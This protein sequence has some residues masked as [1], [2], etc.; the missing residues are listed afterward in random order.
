VAEAAKDLGVIDDR[1]RLTLAHAAEREGKQ[2]GQWKVAVAVAAEAAG[3]D[4]PALLA[5]AQS[6]E[7]AA[8]VQVSTAEF[9]AL[10]VTQRPTF[11]LENSIGDRAVFSGLV[12]AEPMAVTLD[13]MLADQ[14]AYA[15]WKAH[16]GDPP[17]R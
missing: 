10:Q 4:R 12:R 1:V 15:S 11:L 3:L 2:V 5:R 7:I 14:G 13:A 16:F 6:A 8:R 9:H 17:P